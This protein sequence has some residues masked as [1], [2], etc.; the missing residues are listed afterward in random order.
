LIKNVN[1]EFTRRRETALEN[2]RYW[3]SGEKTKAPDSK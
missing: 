1:S 3:K 2:P